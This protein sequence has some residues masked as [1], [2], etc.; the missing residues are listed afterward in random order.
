MFKKISILLILAT[1]L[2]GCSMMR[3]NRKIVTEGYAINLKLDELS[4]NRR[5]EYSGMCK[6][7]DK[8]ILLPQYPSFFRN[9]VGT[10]I[11]FMLTNQQLNEAIKKKGKTE[12]KAKQIKVVNN[13]SYK[14][15]PGY[16]GFEAICYD[17]QYFYIAVE[18]NST[19]NQSGLLKAQLRNNDTELHILNEQSIVLDLPANVFN[20]SYESIFL[21]N[22]SLY[23]IYEANGARIN[24]KQIVKKV[25]KDF[26]SIEDITI[27]PIEF[28]ITDVTDFDENGK[29]WAINYFWPGDL[30]KYNPEDDSIDNLYDYCNNIEQGIE[31][32]IPL[33]I[34]DDAISIDFMREPIYIKRKVLDYS[35]NWEGIVKTEAG[36][37]IVT[38]KFPHTILRYI[39]K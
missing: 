8:V 11:I 22:D 13:L 10:D 35:S 1:L 21:H 20:A 33:K 18:F 12:L 27:E 37:L 4:S 36:F 16:E 26:S 9:I 14:L 31:R 34:E 3:S 32:I 19:T 30:E 39:K 29:G 15:L 6:Y 24:K 23:L 28:R 2:A 17:G 7:N 25:S 38:D 5:A